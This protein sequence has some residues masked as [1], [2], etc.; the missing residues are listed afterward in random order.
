MSAVNYDPNAN[1]EEYLQAFD[2]FKQR[3]SQYNQLTIKEDSEGQSEGQS[4]DDAINKGTNETEGESSSHQSKSGKTIRHS[5]PNKMSRSL[6]NRSLHKKTNTPNNTSVV[7]ENNNTIYVNEILEFEGNCINDS[8]FGAAGPSPPKTFYRN[9]SNPFPSDTKRTEKVKAESSAQKPEKKL[10]EARQRACGKLLSYIR[11]KAKTESNSSGG[12]GSG[13]YKSY[14]FSSTLSDEE[15]F[16]IKKSNGQDIPVDVYD[17]I[18][19]IFG[20]FVQHNVAHDQRQIEKHNSPVKPANVSGPSDIGGISG[21]GALSAFSALGAAFTSFR[22]CEGMIDE[23]FGFLNESKW[24]DY[25]ADE[26]ECYGAEGGEV[27]HVN[28]EVTDLDISSIAGTQ[29]GKLIN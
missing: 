27:Q 29:H 9:N 12:S 7:S 18:V 6:L 16:T 19:N 20:D 5:L 15:E 10:E 23:N 26:S 13:A 1:R 22:Q 21:I 25:L 28:V 24:N 8:S 3:G 4:T 2:E 17:E 11:P 14:D